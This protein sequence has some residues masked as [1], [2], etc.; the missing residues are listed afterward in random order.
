MQSAG[1]DTSVVA[2]TRALP[3]VFRNWSRVRCLEPGLT[4]SPAC[5]MVSNG[6]DTPCSDSPP[7]GF[8]S[9]IHTASM[10][11]SCHGR[12]ANTADTAHA[13][14]C[15]EHTL[16]W[17][18]IKIYSVM[19]Y[20]ILNVLHQ[21]LPPVSASS[22]SYSLRTRFHNRQLSYCHFYQLFNQFYC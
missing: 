12:V 21:I 17:R 18:L 9:S 19:Y 20:I 15:L 16:A 22:H 10:S 8:F 4:T 14:T 5:R 1:T 11:N 6:L 7:P 2:T 13:D 3:R